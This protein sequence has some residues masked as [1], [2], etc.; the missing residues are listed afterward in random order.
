MK[1][2]VV[3]LPI[4]ALLPD[5]ACA[6]YQTRGAFAGAAV[7]RWERLSAQSSGLPWQIFRIVH[8][9]R[10]TKRIGLWV[11]YRT[12]DGLGLYGAALRLRCSH[13]VQE[14]I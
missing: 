3:I 12:K 14:D 6:E 13:K 5:A 1:E 7:V 8:H 11:A 2:A 4:F 10:G 9:G